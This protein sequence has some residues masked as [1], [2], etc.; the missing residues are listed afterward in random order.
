MRY[1]TSTPDIQ[2]PGVPEPI[3]W[4]TLVGALAAERPIVDALG[5]L[6]A[7]DLRKKLVRGGVV[8]LTDAEWLVLKGVA[9]K[10]TSLT[11]ALIFAD[12]AE[13]FF[14]AIADAPTGPPK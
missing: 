11:P 2:I 14:R 4:S 10:P 5:V 13:T 6:G 9:D 3:T 8:E 12:G 7:I 1:V